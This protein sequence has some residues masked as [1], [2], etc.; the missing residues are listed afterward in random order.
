M[1]ELKAID[2]DIALDK[3]ESDGVAYYRIDPKFKEFLQKCD[4]KHGIIG[5]EYDGS[6]NFGVI[7]GKE[8]SK[9]EN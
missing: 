5:F 1:G 9:G 4:D 6:F 2:I 8:A 7:L 3:V